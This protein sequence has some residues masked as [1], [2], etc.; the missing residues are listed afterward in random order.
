M[1]YRS[2]P[3]IVA[4]EKKNEMLYDSIVPKGNIWIGYQY[5]REINNGIY[6]IS[7]GMAPMKVRMAPPGGCLATLVKCP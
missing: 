3:D 1:M 6:H 4:G 7:R 2:R 5:G